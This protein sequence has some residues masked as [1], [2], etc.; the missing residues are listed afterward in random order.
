MSNI[1]TLYGA[2]MYKNGDA[3]PFW[4]MTVKLTDG[5]K[6]ECTVFAVPGCVAVTP[7]DNMTGL[8]PVNAARLEAELRT[9]IRLHYKKEPDK[10]REFTRPLPVRV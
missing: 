3:R 6:Y 1:L 2:Q 10:S 4:R 9:I 7:K 8:P 5:H